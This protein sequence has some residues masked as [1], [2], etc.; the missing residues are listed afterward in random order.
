LCS[1]FDKLS[2][3]GR[4]DGKKKKLLEKFRE[5]FLPAKPDATLCFLIYR[6]I[7]PEARLIAPPPPPRAR[8]GARVQN[9]QP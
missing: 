5:H 9:A 6:L 2:A 7:L 8:A 3:V 1:L 4:K